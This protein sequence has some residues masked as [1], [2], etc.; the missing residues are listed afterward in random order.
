MTILGSSLLEQ[1]VN[2]RQIFDPSQILKKLD[3]LI[4]GALNRTATAHKVNDGMDAAVLVI[5]CD[6]GK[7]VFAGAKSHLYHVIDHKLQSI[8]GCPFPIGS[9]QYNKEKLFKRHQIEFNKGDS[10]YMASDGYQDQ[11]GGENDR[12]FMKKRFL[13]LLEEVSHLPFDQQKQKLKS[14]FEDWKGD[15]RQTD[16]ILVVGIG[17]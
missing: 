12:K 7:A 3:E 11:F 1:I 13:G 5:H 15:R 2:E 10:F 6:D 14:V 4:I 16:D 8:K 9:L 17:F